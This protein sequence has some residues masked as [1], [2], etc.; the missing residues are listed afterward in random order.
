MDIKV[1]Y[2]DRFNNRI[3][4]SLWPSVYVSNSINIG[5]QTPLT[6]NL[7]AGNGNR[8]ASTYHYLQT[9]TWPYTSN[10]A[11]ISQKIVFKLGGG[12]TCCQA[13]SNI[14]LSDNY[15]GNFPLLWTDATAN[16]SVYRAP[17]VPINYADVIWINSVINPYP[18]QYYTYQ[19]LMTLQVLFYSGY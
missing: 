19:N 4:R 7:Y 15:Y 1:L 17:S 11:D 8:G 9:V 3:Y 16:I 6:P 18:Y 10:M 5:S 13:F 2:N 12:I 14:Y